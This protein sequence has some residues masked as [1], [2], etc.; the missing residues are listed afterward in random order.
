MIQFVVVLGLIRTIAAARC[1]YCGQDFVSLGRHV[2][3]CKA[4]VTSVNYPLPTPPSA[5]TAHGIPQTGIPLVLPPIAT[6]DVVC[7]CGRACKGRRGLT[8]HQRSCEF[9]KRL[10]RGGQ[11]LDSP[12]SVVTPPCTEAHEDTDH[13]PTHLTCP[14]QDMNIKTGIRLPKTKCQWA[15]ANA[16]FHVQFA[17]LLSSRAVDIDSDIIRAQDVVYDYFASSCGT[18]TMENSID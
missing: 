12:S 6:D 17:P 8:A 14:S 9:F 18:V 10:T 3:R 13:A 4:R 16:Y 5:T 15:E 1:T 11:L 7:V 2:W